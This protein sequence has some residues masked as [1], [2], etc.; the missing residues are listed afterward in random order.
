[1]RAEKKF[2]LKQKLIAY[3]QEM[4]RFE[5]EQKVY[6]E[7]T[8]LLKG[9]DDV[10]TKLDELIVGTQTMLGSSYMK[11]SLKVETQK[12]ETTLN[13]ISELMEAMMKTQR[14]WMYL[15]PIFSSGDISATM[16]LEARM[17]GEV[18]AL[19]RKTMESIH[20]EPGIMELTEKEGIK[21]SFDDANRKLDKI[22]K[23][24]NDYLEQKRLI[25][26]RFFFLGSDELLQILANTKDPLL[27]QP[28]MNKCFE[29]INSV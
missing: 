8:Y 6:K 2:G 11:G 1:M 21:N 28:Y 22:Q 16:P 18:D 15:E 20:D 4:K 24:L 12:W 27:V 14:N 17:F 3:R 26:A 10:M 25:F 5:L 23:S 29:G 13:N 9:Y 19:W 7:T